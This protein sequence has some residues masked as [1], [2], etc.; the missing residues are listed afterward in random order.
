MIDLSATARDLVQTEE[1]FETIDPILDLSER[2]MLAIGAEHHLRD[3]NIERWR[4]DQPEILMSWLPFR[5]ETHI[6]KNIRVLVKVEQANA[7]RVYFES[8]A[9]Y[10]E[11]RGPGMLIRYWAHF[12]AGDIPVDGAQEAAQDEQRWINKYIQDAYGHVADAKEVTLDQSI[13]I[14]SDGS[15]ESIGAVMSIPPVDP[16]Q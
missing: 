2:S 5:R 1:H 7:F 10:D 13:I 6:G 9:W 3:I 14:W 8:N 16:E 15:T 4:W 11:R 12:P